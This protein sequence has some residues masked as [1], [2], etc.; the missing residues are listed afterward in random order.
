MAFKSK[1]LHTIKSLCYYFIAEIQT[2]TRY[3]MNDN[4]IT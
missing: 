2:K 4:N 1:Y 3:N